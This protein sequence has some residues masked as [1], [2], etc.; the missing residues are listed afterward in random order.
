MSL[1]RG[2]DYYTG[3]IYEAITEASAPPSIAPNPPV[4]PMN[5]IASSSKSKKSTPTQSTED[6]PDE[7]TI[8]VGSIAAGGRYDN[9]VNMFAEASGAKRDPVPCV[10]VSVGVERVYSILEMK[11]R[12]NK[13]DKGG[14]GKETEVYVMNFGKEGLLLER[15]KFVRMLREAGIK[16]C[17]NFHFGCRSLADGADRVHV[18]GITKRSTSIRTSRRRSSPHR[19][20]SRTERAGSWDGENQR[21]AWE[22]GCRG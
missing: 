18:Q 19:G 13:E 3:I 22:G 6:G 15:M 21:T 1:A 4:P 14:R 17:P 16:V 10:G 20:Y 11:R 7:S 9:L 2:L 5:S 12:L 8:G